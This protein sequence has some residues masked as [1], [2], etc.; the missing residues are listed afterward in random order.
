MKKR[1]ISSVTPTEEPLTQYLSLDDTASKI[2]IDPPKDPDI[3]QEFYDTLE[4]TINAFNQSTDF[5]I[6]FPISIDNPNPLSIEIN[7]ECNNPN[8]LKVLLTKLAS[9]TIS[10][11]KE[12]NSKFKPKS[13]TE[14]ALPSTLPVA[15]YVYS[16]NLTLLKSAFLDKDSFFIPFGENSR[17]E[18]LRSKIVPFLKNKPGSIPHQISTQTV[19]RNG[20][21]GL[22]FSFKKNHAEKKTLQEY[23]EEKITQVEANLS[24]RSNTVKSNPTIELEE[25]IKKFFFSGIETTEYRNVFFIKADNAQALLTPKKSQVFNQGDINKNLKVIISS[26]LGVKLTPTCKLLDL[27]GTTCNSIIFEDPEEAESF[28]KLVRAK[29]NP[30]QDW[31]T[32]TQTFVETNSNKHLQIPLLLWYLR[33]TVTENTLTIS[34]EE[35]NKIL[36]DYA[37]I[38]PGIGSFDTI[39]AIKAQMYK[40]V[41]KKFVHQL[42][43]AI[44]KNS[45]GLQ[46]SPTNQNEPLKDLL[47][48][49]YTYCE[50]E[51]PELQNLFVDEEVIIDEELDLPKNTTYTP[52]AEKYGGLFRRPFNPAE[53]RLPTSIQIIQAETIEEEIINELELTAEA[54][55]K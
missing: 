14:I 37:G 49:V 15:K 41:Q 47:K 52:V 7:Q 31:E 11:A 5:S 4:N 13:F 36:K 30:L 46:L 29:N 43:I 45:T 27:N 25:R 21:K 48:K 33:D 26:K 22:K 6:F 2:T 55:P 3:C 28:C 39:A 12:E 50:Q 24:P 34:L 10:I 44:T 54:N 53:N 1:K 40:W 19:E 16:K 17:Q 35:S 18:L 51:Y 9:T 23:V 32:L 38:F 8:I 42:V 20:Q